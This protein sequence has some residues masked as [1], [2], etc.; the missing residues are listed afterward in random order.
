MRSPKVATGSV[1]RQSIKIGFIMGAFLKRL[2]VALFLCCTSAIGAD[3]V[4]MRGS[5]ERLSGHE[6]VV[7]D[8]WLPRIVIDGP[9]S[10]GDDKRF[11]SVLNEAKGRST[12]WERY[13]TVLLNSEGGDVAAAMSIGRMV[14]EAQIVTAIHERSVCAS[15]CILILSGGVWR[16]ARDDTR[17][18]L[19][20]PYFVDPRHATS[21]GYQSFQQA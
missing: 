5:P 3:I 20:R 14:R 17:L 1:L 12:D 7:P 18:G 4:F 8:N 11:F 6:G 10:T 15:A 19:H 2:A 9:I 21:Q 13:R 16:Y